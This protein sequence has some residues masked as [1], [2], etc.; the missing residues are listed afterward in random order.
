MN[1][2]RTDVKKPSA[3]PRPDAD[4]AN[5]GGATCGIRAHRLSAVAIA[6][7]VRRLIHEADVAGIDVHLIARRKQPAAQAGAA[8]ARYRGMGR[9]G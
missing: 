1:F 9:D 8:E 7:I 2:P 6:G 3:A 5:R 4:M